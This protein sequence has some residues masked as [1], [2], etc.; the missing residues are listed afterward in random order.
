[1]KR[2]LSQAA[3][4]RVLTD[5]ASN[6]ERAHVAGCSACAAHQQRLAS[7]MGLVARALSARPELAARQPSR[8]RRGLM[9]GAASAVAVVAIMW[10]EVVAWRV[11]QRLPDAAQ[12]EQLAALADMSAT[13]F[14]LRGEPTGAQA[15]DPTTSLRPIEDAIC[16][17]SDCSALDMDNL[18]DPDDVSDLGPDDGT[19]GGRQ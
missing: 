15:G 5:L 19:L 7:Q 13:L 10:F 8:T 9:I 11:V 3:Q 1:M 16:E 12:A 17:N 2:C 6:E 18:I 14:S 4:A